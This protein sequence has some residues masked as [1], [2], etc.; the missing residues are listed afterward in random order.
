MPRDGRRDLLDIEARVE[1]FI[2]W[3]ATLME[4]QA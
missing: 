4:R 1:A 3:E 2:Q